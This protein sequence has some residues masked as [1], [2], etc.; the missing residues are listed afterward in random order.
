MIMHYFITLFNGVFSFRSNTD[1]DEFYDDE[2]G[3]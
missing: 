3:M 2:D 1:Y